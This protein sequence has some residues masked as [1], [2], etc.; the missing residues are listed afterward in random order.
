MN[1]SS[2]NRLAAPPRRSQEVIA[3][4]RDVTQTFDS[5]LTRALASVNLEVRR[6]EVCALLGPDASGKT[7]TLRLLAGRLRPT[8]GKVKVFGRSPRRTASKARIGY[9]PGKRTR[10]EETGL[11]GVFSRVFTNSRHKPDRIASP[12]A[13]GEQ[14]R[15]ALTRS[16]LGSRDLVLLDEPF[17]DLDEVG[18]REVREFIQTLRDRGKTVIFSSKLLTDASGLCDRAA[19][20]YA[21]KLQAVGALDDLLA[22][23]DAIRYLAPLLPPATAERVLKMIRNELCGAQFGG[24]DSVA[25]ETPPRQTASPRQARPAITAT[26]TET[27]LAPLLQAA[28]SEDHLAVPAIAAD[29]V[30]HAKLAE[31]TQPEKSRPALPA[32]HRDSR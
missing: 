10:K 11:C 3:V 7:T 6:G 25:S 26:A 32:A 5:Y 31:L 4:L 14:R 29:P 20:Y 30:D 9:F 24:N 28:A 1:S 16:V 27:V 21:G 13:D 8:E 18:R 17:S 15:L 23:Q 19:I 2:S 12:R 22:T